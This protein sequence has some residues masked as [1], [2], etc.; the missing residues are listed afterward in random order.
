VIGFSKNGVI[1]KNRHEEGAT[2]KKYG[3]IRSVLISACVLFLAACPPPNQPPPGA[4]H[5]WTQFNASGVAGTDKPIARWAH[6]MA[7]GGGSIVVL[8]GGYSSDYLGDTW[9]YDQ[10]THAWT[11][12]AT[13]GTAGTTKPLP[14]AYFAMAYA[15]GTKVVLF[16]GSTTSTMLGDTWEYDTATHA[17]TEQNTGGV[18]GTDKPDTRSDM[19]MAYAGGSKVVLFGGWGAPGVPLG[20]TWEY[21]DSAH[22]WAETS[23]GGTAGVDKPE[24]RNRHAMA[25]AGGSSVVLFGGQTN[26]VTYGDTWEYDAS[27][28]SW[29]QSNAT[30]TAGVDK[31]AARSLHAMDFMGGSKVLLSGG[32][33]S[34]W[35]VWEYDISTH[36]WTQKDVDGTA[37]TDMPSGRYGHAMAYA[38]GAHVILFG[39]RGSSDLGDTWQY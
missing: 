5:P 9:E 32:S 8:F 19:A 25:Y 11:Q 21:D 39:G 34:L 30:G 22:T 14:R 35:D 20:D 18:A 16:G 38:G 24:V 3:S 12:Y 2:M 36:A 29:V 28:H 10:S 15:G 17:W 4:D 23:A 7:Y 1:L 26:T 33:G 31:P 6:G 13:G 27:A 37:G